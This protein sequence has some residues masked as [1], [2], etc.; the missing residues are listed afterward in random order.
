MFLN[1]QNIKKFVDKYNIPVL[2]H[3]KAW[4]EKDFDFP[5]IEQP[6]NLTERVEVEIEKLFTLV[7]T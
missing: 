2:E 4:I 5:K 7:L 3:H 1:N 6:L